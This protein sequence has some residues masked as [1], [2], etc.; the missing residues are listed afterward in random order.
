MVLVTRVLLVYIDCSTPGVATP[1]LV[2][3]EFRLS[4]V[5][6]TAISSLRNGKQ[7]Y[8]WIR[9]HSALVN[10]ERLLQIQQKYDMR[11]VQMYN[12]QKSQRSTSKLASESR[13]PRHIHIPSTERTPLHVLPHLV[14]KSRTKYRP[15]P[16]NPHHIYD[17]T[18]KANPRRAWPDNGLGRPHKTLSQNC[19]AERMYPQTH[20][21]LGARLGTWP[22]NL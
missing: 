13:R 7:T 16:Q 3:I 4:T 5:S 6:T 22:A 14:N 1:G 21:R 9:R 19:D 17:Q 15:L 11:T 8:R 18:P 20:R 2:G 12:K 10:N